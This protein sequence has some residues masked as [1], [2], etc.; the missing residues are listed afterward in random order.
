MFCTMLILSYTFMFAIGI[1]AQKAT[2][3]VIDVKVGLKSQRP[4]QALTW[5]KGLPDDILGTI[6]ASAQL[7]VLD[8]LQEVKD[9]L[10]SALFDLISSLVDKVADLITDLVESIANAAGV[11]ETV[12]SGLNY[13]VTALNVAI[14]EELEKRADSISLARKALGDKGSVQDTKD[15]ANAISRLRF[16]KLQAEVANDPNSPTIAPTQRE[17]AAAEGSI[18]AVANRSCQN[19][20]N[21]FLSG[22]MS[23]YQV[24]GSDAVAEINSVSSAIDVKTQ[25]QTLANIT[26]N[27]PAD[28][29]A[30]YVDFNNAENPRIANN[31]TDLTQDSNSNL[32]ANSTFTESTTLAAANFQ[33]QT[34]S[35]DQC[36]AIQSSTDVSLK[37]FDVQPVTANNPLGFS[38]VVDALKKLVE[39]TIAQLIDNIVGMITKTISNAVSNL[40]RIFGSGPIGRIVGSVERG[41]NDSIQDLGQKLE[42]Q[43]EIT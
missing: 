26:N 39:K 15:L 35:P 29:K 28:C 21:F 6:N 42:D 40:P 4:S 10:F 27:A 19:Q 30:P 31:G 32:F 14:F 8:V 7:P 1:S 37:A 11:Y 20:P 18:A 17:L 5:L 13:T 38:G 12:K 23:G 34:L 36:Q 33:I 16:A 22:I 3:D 43:I 9:A 41:V 24:C 25:R 2:T